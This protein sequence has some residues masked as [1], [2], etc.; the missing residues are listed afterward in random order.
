M[1]LLIVVCLG[2]MGITIYNMFSFNV[3]LAKY[4]YVLL[5]V[6]LLPVEYL[7]KGRIEGVFQEQSSNVVCFLIA[8]ILFVIIILLLT[9]MS[10]MFNNK[11]SSNKRTAFAIVAIVLLALFS[12]MFT[13]GAIILTIKFNQ[14]SNAINSLG[15]DFIKQITTSIGL[16]I[17]ALKEI[18]VGYAGAIICLFAFISF[19]VG[20][21]HKSTKVKILSSIN[22]YSSEYQ[23]VKEPAK[24][25]EENKEEEKTEE[26]PEA[27]PNAQNLIKKIMQLEELKKAGKI[28][29]V[30]YTRL[31]QKAIR[32]YKTKWKSFL[33]ILKSL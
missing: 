31:R 30:D 15:P 1:A 29:N 33:Q 25:K 14:I 27:N 10:K 23:E 5:G 7:L 22:F 20:I 19:I 3:E 8:F 4:I 16:N 32:R 2:A 11:Y 6:V 24:T 28:S 13:G 26:M 9:S 17:V 21:S 18:I 12:I